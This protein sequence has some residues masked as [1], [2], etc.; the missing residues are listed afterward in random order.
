MHIS[1][2][3]FAVVAASLLALLYVLKIELLLDTP[4]WAVVAP[5]R[6]AAWRLTAAR[7]VPGLSLRGCS[8]AEGSYWHELRGVPS[9]ASWF[10]AVFNEARTPSAKVIALAG[11]QAVS[12]EEYALLRPHPGITA[13]DSIPRVGPAPSALGAEDVLDSLDAG[14]VRIDLEAASAWPEC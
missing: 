4:I 13:R 1:R 5:T 8:S 6:Y 14:I 11:L 3:S 7:Q 12:P 9:A 10:V 2:P